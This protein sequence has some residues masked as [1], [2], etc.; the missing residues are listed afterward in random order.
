VTLSVNSSKRLSDC[1]SEQLVDEPDPIGVEHVA[2]TVAMFRRKNEPGAASAHD[3]IACFKKPRGS[4]KI[5]SR[6]CAT[7]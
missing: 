1:S 2:L 7:P 3:V 4:I 6:D 5:F